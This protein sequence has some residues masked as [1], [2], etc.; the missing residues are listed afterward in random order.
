MADVTVDLSDHKQLRSTLRLFASKVAPYAARNTLNAIV[1][2]ARREW[3]SQ[4]KSKLILR[5]SYT[6][7]SLRVVKAHGI[8]IENMRAVVGSVADYMDE[9]EDGETVTGKGKSKP[10]PT[11]AAAGQAQGSK[12]RTKLVRRRNYM[13]SLT[14]DA[15]ARKGKTQRQR[16]AI[17]IRLA[18]KQG[19]GQRVALLELNGKRGIFRVTG[20]RT[21]PRIRMMWNLSKQSVR[22]P[23]S[24]TLHITLRELQPRMHIISRKELID[25]GRK[26]GIRWFG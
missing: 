1:F 9:Q 11:S 13:A 24:R 12:P 6:E 20:R 22:I 4:L 18:A 25:M 16:N 3:I 5:N 8:R 19:N 14:L 21:K 2:E 15:N 23:P 7:R 10:I 26:A 17:A